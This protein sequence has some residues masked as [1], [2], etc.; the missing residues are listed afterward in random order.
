MLWY[1]NNAQ[2]K[3]TQSEPPTRTIGQWPLS[4]VSESMQ[5]STSNRV[6]GHDVETGACSMI[7]NGSDGNGFRADVSLTASK[8]SSLEPMR[9]PSQF[10]PISLN[11]CHALYGAVCLIKLMLQP[12]WRARCDIGHQ[13]PKARGGMLCALLQCSMHALA[14]YLH[15][16]YVAEA[17][18]GRSPFRQ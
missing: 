5:S 14:C 2:S 4:F 6:S 18:P 1:P 7:R 3:A 12:H 11:S 13:L 15:L 9:H 17:C 10:S 8:A 16:Q